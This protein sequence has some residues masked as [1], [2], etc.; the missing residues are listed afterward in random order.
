MLMAEN[1][2]RGYVTEQLMLIL[3]EKRQDNVEELSRGW[4]R[5]L[6]APS[7]ESHDPFAYRDLRSPSIERSASPAAS[8]TCRRLR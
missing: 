7:A 2:W 3:S 4:Q 8:P 6:K 5:H 1:Q